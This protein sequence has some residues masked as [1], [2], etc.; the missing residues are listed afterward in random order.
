MSAHTELNDK[1]S[2][3]SFRAEI[4]TKILH[5][6]PFSTILQSSKLPFR[7]LI[8]SYINHY[9][10]TL[11]LPSVLVSRI[12]LSPSLAAVLWSWMVNPSARSTSTPGKALCAVS[13]KN[14]SRAVACKLFIASFP[15]STFNVPSVCGN[16]AKESLRS[17]KGSHTA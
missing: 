11:C 17:R 3:D 1:L 7:S 12:V 4:H 2:L 14:P 16:S 8:F 5:Y 15:L 10:Q 13:V 9:H 6:Y